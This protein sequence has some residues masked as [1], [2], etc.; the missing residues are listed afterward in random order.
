VPKVQISS[1]ESSR[2][3]QENELL[4]ALKWKCIYWAFYHF[5]KYCP[6]DRR[7]ISRLFKLPRM[8]PWFTWF[9]HLNKQI[10]ATT[11]KLRHQTN[12]TWIITCDMQRYYQTILR[13]NNGKSLLNHPRLPMMLYHIN[14][15]SKFKKIKN[16]NK[17]L[18]YKILKYGPV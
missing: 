7:G 4:V 6:A 10:K 18:N 3:P 14:F 13:R 1:G 9:V 5:Q 11:Q 12:F 17:K 15:S 8:K 2:P 16:L